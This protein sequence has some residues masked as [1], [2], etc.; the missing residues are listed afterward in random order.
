MPVFHLTDTR[1]RTPCEMPYQ[2]E[3]LT[4]NQ[5]VVSSSLT[6]GAIADRLY[7]CRLLFSTPTID[8][9]PHTLTIRSASGDATAKFTIEAEVVPPAPESTNACVLIVVGVVALGAC[10]AVVVFIIRKRKRH[11]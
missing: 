4:V 1:L 6:R 2:R 5:G 10:A 8:K 9:E 7:A 11:N 3:H